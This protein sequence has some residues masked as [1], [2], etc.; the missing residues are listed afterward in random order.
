MLLGDQEPETDEP[1]EKVEKLTGAVNGDKGTCGVDGE[2]EHGKVTTTD[3]T[4][5]FFGLNRLPGWKDNGTDADDPV[6]NS[7]V[8]RPGVRQPLR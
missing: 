7:R 4:Q 6:T 5:Y 3:G 2:G 8:D 1:L